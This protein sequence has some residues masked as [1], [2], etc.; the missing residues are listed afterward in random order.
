MS[1]SKTHA[2]ELERLRQLQG[3]GG[4]LKLAGINM[5]TQRLFRM[6]GVKNFF[7][8][9]DTESLAINAFQKAA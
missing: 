9:F 1:L 6:M 3:F 8:T 7:K 2:S 4:D 5:Y